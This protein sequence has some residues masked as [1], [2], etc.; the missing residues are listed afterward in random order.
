MSPKKTTGRIPAVS[1]AALAAAATWRLQRV[2][3][4]LPLRSYLTFP[5]TGAQCAAPP[6]HSPPS[7]WSPCQPASIAS[8]MKGR[9]YGPPAS[10]ISSV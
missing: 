3:A 5:G 6:G 10:I 9:L 2:L 8:W 4:L 7:A 1:A